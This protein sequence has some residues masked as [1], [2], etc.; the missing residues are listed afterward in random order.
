M[1]WP[2][3]K[4]KLNFMIALFS[5]ECYLSVTLLAKIKFLLTG[6]LES[7][8]HDCTCFHVSVIYEFIRGMRSAR[9]STL[10]IAFEQADKST[11]L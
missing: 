4:F 11:S 10:D 9:I 3:S 1:K 2:V 7:R 5:R 8:F 6:E